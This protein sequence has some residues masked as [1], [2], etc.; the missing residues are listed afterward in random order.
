M[1]LLTACVYMFASV[2]S[3]PQATASGEWFDGVSYTAAH[4]SLP[5]GTWL[6]VTHKGKT[7]TVRITDRGPYKKRKGQPEREL[8]L[9]LAAARAIHF[10]G[11]GWVCVQRIE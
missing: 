9:S 8:D 5:F 7:I 6:F 11:L 4:K 3:Q 2:Y 10:N 1:N